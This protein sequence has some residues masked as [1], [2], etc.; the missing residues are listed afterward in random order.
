MIKLG[1]ESP[2]ILFPALSLL[3]LAY[4]NRF[5]AIA[6]LIRNLHNRYLESPSD[7]LLRQIR[8]LR[9]RI[10]LIRDMQTLGVV[11]IFVSVLCMVMIYKGWEE[12][13]N[14]LFGASLL[15]MLASLV[16]SISEIHISTHAL[17]AEIE[18]II[19]DEQAIIDSKPK[20]GH[21]RKSDK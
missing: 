3:L 9:R 2:A 6:S 11:A 19:D 21:F 5:L 12:A 16:F 8:N 1:I 7:N 15:V 13:A 18:D 10:K 17:M 4:T 20:K 14:Y